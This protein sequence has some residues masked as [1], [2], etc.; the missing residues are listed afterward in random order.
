MPELPEVETVRRGLAPALEGAT[1]LQA[2][3]RRPDL[4]FPFPENLAE[5]L[6]GARVT[7]LTRRAKYLL[8]ETDRGETFILHLGMSGSYRV[9]QPDQDAVLTPG[10]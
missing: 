6:T 4:R 7:A 3:V 10:T 8:M 1:I 5:R 2:D 9:E